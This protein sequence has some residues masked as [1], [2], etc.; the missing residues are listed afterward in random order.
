MKK[1]LCCLLLTVFILSWCDWIPTN[2]WWFWNNNGEKTYQLHTYRCYKDKVDN[3]KSDDWEEQRQASQV[4]FTKE[5]LNNF[6]FSN[7]SDE[8]K[9]IIINL[10]NEV[11]WNG[12]ILLDWS[13]ATIS[14]KLQSCKVYDISLDITYYDWS[15]WEEWELNKYIMNNRIQKLRNFL[16]GD[17]SG[18]LK[19]KEGDKINLR[20]IGTIKENDS[21]ANLKDSVEFYYKTPCISE[22]VMYTVIDDDVE[23]NNIRWIINYYYT[24]KIY[25][26]MRK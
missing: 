11:K 20:F 15:S 12:E 2:N 7:L 13:N 16:E 4:T 18:N 22:D 26:E 3:C 10:N 9:K 21:Q 19:I 25:W 14:N 23:I 8:N 1:L 5:E 17:N 6:K 24:L